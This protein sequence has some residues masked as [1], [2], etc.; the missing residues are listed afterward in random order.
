M[1]DENRTPSKGVEIDLNLPGLFGTYVLDVQR[2]VDLVSLTYV[3]TDQVQEV[4]YR[5][6]FAFFHFYPA[7]SKRLEL[8]EARNK[9]KQ[10]LLGCFLTDAISATGAFLDEC[11]KRCGAI[12]LGAKGVITG[13]ELMDFQGREF[14]KFHANSF[15]DKLDHLEAEFDVG[16]ELRRHFMSLNRTRNCLVHRQGVVGER[17]TNDE[18]ELIVQ[19]RTWQ[20]LIKCPDGT[21]ETIIDEPG[22]VEAGSRVTLEEADRERV[23]RLG[24][25]VEFEAEELAHTAVTLTLLGR[26]LTEAVTQYGVRKGVVT[27]TRAARR[28]RARQ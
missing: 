8:E 28:S 23:F 13:Q 6:N 5:Q 2:L 14:R 21:Q 26:Q 3:G 15:P 19:W 24:E 17:D 18:G 9:A 25:T 1:A 27:G 22:R 11:W 16:T 20:I 7:G 12:R 10:W 4:R